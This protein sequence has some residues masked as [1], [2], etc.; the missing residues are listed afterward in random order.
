M[1]NDNGVIVTVGIVC[2]GDRCAIVFPLAAPSNSMTPDQL[3]KDACINWIAAQVSGLQ[4]LLANTAYI[5]FIAGEGMVDGLVPYRA[6]F[7]PTTYPGLGTTDIMPSNVNGLLAFYEDPADMGPPGQR[8]RVGKTFIPGVPRDQVV[9]DRFQVSWVG[10]AQAL[11]DQLQGGFASSGD[12]SVN[13]Y[14][15]LAAGPRAPGTPVRR[16]ITDLARGYI[17]TQRRRLIPR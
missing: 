1:V 6:D 13:W 11:A 17:V 8:M 12:P 14:R 5:S 7:D 9:G 16:V 2:N 3:C 4:A 10:S 15:I